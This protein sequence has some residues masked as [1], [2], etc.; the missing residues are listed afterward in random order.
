M[1]LVFLL[2]MVQSAFAITA[3]VAVLFSASLKAVPPGVYAG[4]LS[5][6]G[7]SYPDAEKAIESNYAGRF[8]IKSLQLEV[9]NGEIYEIPFSQIDAN[10]DG[11]ATVHLLKTRKGIKA[12][13][14][15]FNFYFGPSRPILQPA[16]KFN[17]GKLRKELLDLS[18]KIYTAPSNAVI[19]YKDGIVDKKAETNG[20]SLNVTNTVKVIRDRLLTNPWG[21]VKLSR[22]GNFELQAVPP[23]IKLKDYDEIQ[24]VFAEYTTKIVDEELSDSIELAVEAINAVV[25]PAAVD[26]EHSQVFSF[27]EGLKAENATFENDNEGYDQ[28]ASTLYAA[29]LSAGIPADSIT[30]MQHK[31]LADYIEPGLDAWISGSAGDLRFSNTFSNKIAIFAQMEGDRVRVAI[32]GSISDNKGKYKIETEITQKFAPPVYNVENRSLKPGEKVVLSPG[33]EGVM[34]N[35]YRNGE[36]V[37]TDKYE[38]E[39]A[40][41][42]IGPNTDWKNDHK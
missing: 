5:I 15:F 39:K 9:E 25:L 40:I 23:A 14:D 38:A 8:K 30:R 4:E 37:G 41:V 1:L 19:S 2:I 32:A 33:K 16:I 20:I 22:A 26:S 21:T 42:Q 34:V 35:V 12:L 27:V 31:L 24:Q 18:E 36:L 10:I 7:M 13:P 3:G 29:L 11:T 17:E 6:G 28:V